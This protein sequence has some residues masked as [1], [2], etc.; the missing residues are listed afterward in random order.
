MEYVD[1]FLNIGCIYCVDRS[2]NSEQMI[3]RESISVNNGKA[4]ASYSIMCKTEC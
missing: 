2:V 4:F 1:F 3:G